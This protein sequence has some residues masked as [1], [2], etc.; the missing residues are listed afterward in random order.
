MVA[1]A[2]KARGFFCGHIPI[3]ASFW[4]APLPRGGGKTGG[5]RGRGGDI[6]DTSILQSIWLRKTTQEKRETNAGSISRIKYILVFTI[7]LRFIYYLDIYILYIIYK[8]RVQMIF[9]SSAVLDERPSAGG[10]EKQAGGF[11]ES[12]K[13]EN[14]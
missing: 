5:G 6:Y 9:L 13:R 1:W 11:P 7:R 4:E 3:Y 2:I 10:A 8:G 12:W 14:N